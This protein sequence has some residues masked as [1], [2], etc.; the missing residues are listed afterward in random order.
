M[1]TI[2]DRAVRDELIDRINSLS[3]NNEV[4]WGQMNVYQMIKH[5]CIYDSWVL[6][7]NNPKYRQTL[8]GKI[9]GKMALKSMTKD[10]SPVKRNMPTIKEFIVKK[11][12][13]DV[14]HQ[15][16]IWISL[17]SEYENYSNPGFI[18]TFFGKMTREQVGILAYKHADHHLRQF[19]A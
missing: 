3:T 2:F 10:D 15:K 18:H 8:S 13:G 16:K 1:K 5:C 19:G 17:I 7:K 11:R 6:G 12:D 4:Q 9:F 14:E